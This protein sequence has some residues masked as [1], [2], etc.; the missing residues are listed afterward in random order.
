MKVIFVFYFLVK[1]G[2]S[3]YCN[4]LLYNEQSPIDLVD[5]SSIDFTHDSSIFVNFKDIEGSIIYF[6]G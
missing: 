4:N 3:L 5:L 6:Q 2:L 1:F